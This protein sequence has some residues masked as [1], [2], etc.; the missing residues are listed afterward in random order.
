MIVLYWVGGIIVSFFTISFIVDKMKMSSRKERIKN[1]QV[2]DL[3]TLNNSD[4]RNKVN[5]NGKKFG[6]L[7][8]WDL[9]SLYISDGT[10]TV[11]KEDYDVLD[12]NY[13]AY[14]RENYNRAKKIM[15]VEPLFEGNPNKQ[16][17]TSSASKKVYD[18][19]VDLLTEVECQV[20]L[21]KALEE[22]NFE[23]AEL[24][25]KQLEKFR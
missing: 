20:F 13:S 23:A 11:Y 16:K 21:K 3:L 7:K 8:G 19:P 5:R 15:G 1:W 4:I 14:W 17:S 12:L 9:N 10:D 18:K 24:I 25:K 22:E 2:N 6:V